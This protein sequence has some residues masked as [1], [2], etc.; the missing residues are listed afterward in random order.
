M[1]NLVTSYD[2]RKLA[3][4]SL[5]SCVLAI[6]IALI[7][8]TAIAAENDDAEAEEG[9][10]VI[11]VGS[12]IKREDFDSASPIITVDAELL[13][14]TGYTN[15]EDALNELPQLGIGTNLGNNG[16]SGT[17]TGSSF[18]NLRSMGSGRTLVLVNGKRMVP[19]SLSQTSVDLSNIPVALVEKIEIF[20][21]G[22]SAVYGSD[23]I[24]GVINVTLKK[25]FQGF[26]INF[27]GTLPEHGGA[28]TQTGSLTMGGE[29]G[30]GK[31]NISGGLNFS[32]SE[33]LLQ[34]DRDFTTGDGYIGTVPNLQ[35]TSSF[36][37]IPN[38]LII[39]NQTQSWYPEN[40]GVTTWDPNVGGYVTYYMDDSGNLILNDLPRFGALG[41]F[42]EGGPGF[43]FAKYL[44]QLRSKQEVL[45]SFLNLNYEIDESMAFYSSFQIATSSSDGD[46][47]PNF[48]TSAVTVR[49]D[50]PFNTDSVN[51][52]MDDRGITELS[53]ANGHFVFRTNSDI[54]T[55][56]QYNERTTYTGVFGLNG[57][58]ENW[59]WDVS[60]Q[61]GE[62]KSSTT[63]TGFA[64]I[65]RLA[66]AYDVIQGTDGPQCRTMINQGCLPLRVLGE[67][68]DQAALDWVR[69]VTMQTQKNTQSIF[70][71]YITGEIFDL[72]G[73][74]A[75]IVFGTEYREDTIQFNPDPSERSGNI[76]LAGENNPIPES[77]LDVTE[78]F[79]EINLPVIETLE[80]GAAYRWSDYSTV[81]SV[82]AWSAT[83]DFRPIDDIAF[84]MTGSTSIRAPSVH[85]LFNPGNTF[86]N[87][88]QDPCDVNFITS[89]P[90]PPVRRENCE[91]QVGVG[92]TDPLTGVT[93]ATLSGG[94]PE[95]EPEEADTF[96]AG[97]VITPTAVPELNISIDWW[98]I[99]LT[100]KID[101]K[102]VGQILS[103]CY[104]TPGLSNDACQAITRR[105]S[106]DAIIRINGGQV[107]LG[108]VDLEGYDIGV[109]YKLDA[110]NLFND[111]PGQFGVRLITTK[112]GENLI[113]DDGSLTDSLGDYDNPEWAGTFT[114]E[115]EADDW[116]VN[117]NTI[118][119]GSSVADPDLNT[120]DDD[121][122]AINYDEVY[123]MGNGKVDALYRFDL[124]GHY[125][126]SSSTSLSFGIRNL[127]DEEPPRVT[128]FFWGRNGTVDV[129][130]R[131][132]VLNVTMDL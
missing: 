42:R 15:I 49:R 97:I 70:S 76:V 73:G 3:G 44:F 127:T 35:N 46:F 8:N 82:D 29:F 53:P 86:F 90:N 81:G 121:G 65:D 66:A 19:S 30:G 132:Y 94:N 80:I 83:I 64:Y 32:N 99:E 1:P 91:S 95:L 38:V 125:A 25:D 113:D 5:S 72:P 78:F 116:G 114:I 21:G 110:S 130:G 37:G 129:I 122:N 74:G 126:L 50:N 104:D 63:G 105:G 12:R 4:F 24:A 75:N 112:L 20:T 77:S 31:G 96:T 14:Q 57:Y 10:K 36:D 6:S 47:Q 17:E 100:N 7:P 68:T 89:G 33:R 45:N 16:T 71:G 120:E 131:T 28:E 102:L 109:E 62:S 55:R 56:Q 59:D 88:I 34:T 2:K 98:R 26:R 117:L 67:N 9:Q 11:I 27:G 128:D 115:Y 18:A 87:S 119:R 41:E 22:A 93:R 124:N 39:K 85:D 123:P 103:D 43:S 13:V 79:T 111:L 23:A 108:Q 48:T 107:N 51:A 54:G 69:A 40:G 101:T 92:F 118:F 61:H 52:F 58:I 84:R 106:D 60:V